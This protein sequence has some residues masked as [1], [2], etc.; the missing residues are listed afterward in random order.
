MFEL[1]ILHHWYFSQDK[2][3]RLIFPLLAN[4]GE[5]TAATTTSPPESP[6]SQPNLRRRLGTPVVKALKPHTQIGMLVNALKDDVGGDLISQFQNVGLGVN[7]QLLLPT[8][9]DDESGCVVEHK[10]DEA[11]QH[12]SSKTVEG[13]EAISNMM[14]NEMGISGGY[15]PVKASITVGWSSESRE[16]KYHFASMKV[17]STFHRQKKYDLNC[18]KRKA[19]TVFNQTV[20]DQMKDYLD[21]IKDAE[22]PGV[23]NQTKWE[24]YMS[25]FKKFTDAF[26][27][28]VKTKSI[29]GALAIQM[30]NMDTS[31]KEEAETY[32]VKSTAALN[33]ID[34]E[35]KLTNSFSK[36]SSGSTTDSNITD[37]WL[38]IGVDSTKK[39]DWHNVAIDKTGDNEIQQIIK[40]ELTDIYKILRGHPDMKE[41]QVELKRLARYIHGYS[42]GPLCR[43]DNKVNEYNIGNCH[44]LREDDGNALDPVES[45]AYTGEH[46]AKDRKRKKLS[47]PLNFCY[48]AD[49]HMLDGYDDKEW[50]VDGAGS[51]TGCETK[52]EVEKWETAES[53]EEWGEKLPPNVKK[54]WK[55]DFY[56][57]NDYDDSDS[58]LGQ[59]HSLSA[60][61]CRPWILAH[62]KQDYTTVSNENPVRPLRWKCYD[63]SQCN[64]NQFCE[65]SWDTEKE[66][67]CLPRRGS[68]SDSSLNICQE[69]GVAGNIQWTKNG[70]FFSNKCK[71]N[72]KCYYGWGSWG[73]Q[74][75]QWFCHEHTKER[76]DEY[77]EETKT[78][79]KT[80]LEK[81]ENGVSTL[82][83]MR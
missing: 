61:A 50:Q 67:Q 8:L 6:T 46:K 68:E 29:Y 66:G 12:Y 75:G 5:E 64:Y 7:S 13:V 74:P 21:K 32:E 19:K 56:I 34:S 58:P 82:I 41:Y 28:H 3:L 45:L 44:R 55:K 57:A 35:V 83:W 4:A 71:A 42:N 80:T 24:K 60:Y 26:G 52:K 25:L 30:F 38:K 59:F 23:G 27:T 69:T 49:F 39:F 70:G 14:A 36:S 9:K 16:S 10:F 2:M 17:G 31:S 62:Q 20:I 54:T 81:L 76:D 53:R 1:L 22:Y 11:R 18:V 65:D 15:G 37:A 77:E 33:K 79:T 51:L 43:C 40:E 72:Y 47:S 73:D 63:H 78:K 48:V